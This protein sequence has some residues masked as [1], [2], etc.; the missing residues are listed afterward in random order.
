M[1]EMLGLR[2]VSPVH[3]SKPPSPSLEKKPIRN[4]SGSLHKGMSRMPIGFRA[5]S[6]F[7]FFAADSYCIMHVVTHITHT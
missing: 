5:V 1:K 4:R 6:I 7:Y 2:F 3:S